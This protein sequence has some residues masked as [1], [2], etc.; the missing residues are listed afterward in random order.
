MVLSL[1]KEAGATLGMGTST[2][3][4]RTYFFAYAAPRPPGW[5]AHKASASIHPAALSPIINVGE[6]VLPLVM[7]GITLASATR[8]PCTP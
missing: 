6:F 1:P 3:S 4:V 5:N 7:D 2:S 8:R